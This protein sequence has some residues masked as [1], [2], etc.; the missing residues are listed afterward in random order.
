MPSNHQRNV[1]VPAHESSCMY[2]LGCKYKEVT[3]D[4]PT[5]LYSYI[6]T[7]KNPLR[8]LL[9]DGDATF[10]WVHIQAKTIKFS[11]PSYEHSSTKIVLVPSFHI[12]LAAEQD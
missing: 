12:Q 9:V 7:I 2:H 10:S 11:L 1:H 4:R 6:F 3:F 8:C 5:T